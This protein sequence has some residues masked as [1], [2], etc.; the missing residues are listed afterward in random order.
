[1]EVRN[2]IL[3]G[4]INHNFIDTAKALDEDLTC[5]YSKLHFGVRGKNHEIN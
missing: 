1:M 3:T 2:L 4:G 5:F